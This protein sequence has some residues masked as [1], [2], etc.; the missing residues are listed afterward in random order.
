MLPPE[1]VKIYKKHV[2]L[3]WNTV[4]EH[5]IQKSPCMTVSTTLNVNMASYYLPATYEPPCI[6]S[7]Y[8][9]NMRPHGQGPSLHSPKIELENWGWTLRWTCSAACGNL[10]L[11]ITDRSSQ[12]QKL[13]EPVWTSLHTREIG[14]N[15]SK[16]SIMRDCCLLYSAR[17]NMP[18]C[19]NEH[20]AQDKQ[21]AKKNLM[22]LLNC[23]ELLLSHIVS[24]H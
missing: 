14:K 1:T 17:L 19:I 10:L 15:P 6:Y 9:L 18:I 7:F 20:L 13:I 3:K 16:V 4:L 24:V 5:I 11:E 22:P 21:Q 23:I 8:T 12:L 2:F